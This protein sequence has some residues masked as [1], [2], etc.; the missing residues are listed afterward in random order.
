MSG[1][2]RYTLFECDIAALNPWL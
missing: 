2:A 1:G